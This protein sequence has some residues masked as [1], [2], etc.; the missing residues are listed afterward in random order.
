LQI[1]HIGDDEIHAEH[2]LVGKHQPTIYDDNIVPVLVDAHVLADLAHSA[3]WNDADWLRARGS[4]TLRG[5]LGWLFWFVSPSQTILSLY[6]AGSTR[7]LFPKATLWENHAGDEAAPRSPPV[8]VPFT[9]SQMRRRMR[10]SRRI[11]H[12]MRMNTRLEA[13]AK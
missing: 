12:V 13:R 2:L 10:E 3:Q 4:S 11:A 1:R 9:L 8:R 7:Y 5:A 6:D